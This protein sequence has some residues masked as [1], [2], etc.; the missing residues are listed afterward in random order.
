MCKC[1]QN[2]VRAELTLLGTCNKSE[3]PVQGT[4]GTGSRAC[5]RPSC[6]QAASCSSAPSTPG[7]GQLPV[8]SQALRDLMELAEDGM[9]LTQY[10]CTTKGTTHRHTNQPT[11]GVK[12]HLNLIY[13]LRKLPT[14]YFCCLLAL[15][16]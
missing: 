2:T 4:P 3:S 9:T 6:S 1:H 16:I 12:M 13:I 10:G 7:T 11:S 15:Y 8:G 5:N 14:D